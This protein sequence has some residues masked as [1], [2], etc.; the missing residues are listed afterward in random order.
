[1]QIV[2]MLGTNLAKVAA[3]GYGCMPRPCG[4]SH[5]NP[6]LIQQL[7]MLNLGLTV[8]DE[9]PLTQKREDTNHEYYNHKSH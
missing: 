9:K 6:R 3:K 1:M 5:R 2:A 8:Q 7:I 4:E